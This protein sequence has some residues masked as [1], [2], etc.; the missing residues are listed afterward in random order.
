MV[1]SLHWNTYYQNLYKTGRIVHLKRWLDDETR[2]PNS[3][4]LLE[5]DTVG[6]LDRQ[7][8]M[9]VVDLAVQ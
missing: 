9:G 6:T 1:V 8:L 5:E 4:T 2:K 3:T 7:G